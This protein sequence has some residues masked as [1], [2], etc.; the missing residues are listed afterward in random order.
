MA[1]SQTK[2]LLGIDAPG[3]KDALRLCRKADPD[4]EHAVHVC[5]NALALFDC[6]KNLHELGKKARRLLTLSALLHDTGWSTCP[7][8]HHKGSMDFVLEANLPDVSVRDRK[9]IACIA[10]YHRK[11]LPKSTHKVFRELP[12]KTQNKVARLAAILRIADGL[13]R[14]H[15]GTME[16]VEMK[17]CGLTVRLSIR[18]SHRSMEDISGA[19]KKRDLF[20]KV[21]G[22]ILEIEVEGK[23]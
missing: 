2:E 21:F 7:S 20:E 9:V 3:L 13:D 17:R 11:A 12:H 23:E 19:L 18:Q 4:P 15:G 16:S 5:H 8:Q 14:T 22:V 10:R 1:K 6:L